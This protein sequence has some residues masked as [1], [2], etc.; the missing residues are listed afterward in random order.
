MDLGHGQRSY[1]AIAQ[2]TVVARPMRRAAVR[3]RRHRSCGVAKSLQ[4]KTVRGDRRFHI[5]S[6]RAYPN[7]A[8]VA[9]I[10]HLA[11]RVL[12]ARD[13]AC[14][15]RPVASVVRSISQVR[16]DLADDV[17]IETPRVA[18]RESTRSAAASSPL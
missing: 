1:A 14:L 7:E 15:D 10:D 16:G 12:R 18:G 13:V 9:A 5:D 11:E 6:H 3:F 8:V 17:V 2:A 4:A